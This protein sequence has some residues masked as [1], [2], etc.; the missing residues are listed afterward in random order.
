ME[1]GKAPEPLQ[2]HNLW[3]KHA[4]WGSQNH[5]G[6]QSHLGSLAA[7]PGGNITPPLGRS[8]WSG[9]MIVM[10]VGVPVVAHQ[11]A[12]SREVEVVLEVGELSV[13]APGLHTVMDG[14]EVFVLSVDL[15]DD[16]SSVSLQ[17]CVSF[18]VAVVPLHFCEGSGVVKGT[19]HFSQGVVL[20]PLGL[21]EFVKPNRHWVGWLT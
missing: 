16:C 14:G 4:L 18:M 7:C 5:S 2:K 19:G 9:V 12:L 10:G 17:L 15:C 11:G 8:S 3:M 20:S 21:E 1:G 13:E 6:L